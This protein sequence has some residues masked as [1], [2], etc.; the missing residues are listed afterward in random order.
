MTRDRTFELDRRLKAFK[1]SAFYIYTKK[2]HLLGN[3]SISTRAHTVGT[4]MH[5]LSEEGK[6]NLQR[7]C[8]MLVEFHLKAP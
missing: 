6:K 4:S 2:N 5:L 3:L 8:L 7:N 1:S